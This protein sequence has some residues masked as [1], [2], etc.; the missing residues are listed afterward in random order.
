MGE[1]SGSLDKSNY[2]VHCNTSKEMVVVGNSKGQGG[3]AIFKTNKEV[4]WREMETLV[5]LC[6]KYFLFVNSNMFIFLSH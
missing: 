2:M 1:L 5:T 6:W 3:I 4:V